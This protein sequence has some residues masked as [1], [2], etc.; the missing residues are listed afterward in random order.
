MT[1]AL[2]VAAFF[3]FIGITSLIFFFL[4]CII[5]LFT[6]PFDRRLRAL[7]LFT[8]FWASLY[9]WVM[10]PW[11]IRIY[12]REKI[13]KNTTYMVVS[14][15]QS[16][17][18]ILVAFRLFFHFKWVSKIE[19]F[20]VPLIGWN[21]LLNRYI[22][23]KRGD[24]ES[25]ARMME[26]SEKRIDEGSSVFFFPEGSRSHDGAVK[27]FKP[28]AFVLAKRKKIP[29]LPI[30]ISGTN[31]A[32]PKYSI[33]YHGVHTILIKVFDEIPYSAFQGL[34][35]EET[36]EMVRDF[37]IQKLDMMKSSNAEGV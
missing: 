27:P 22:K 25:I 34:S 13:K 10:P 33:K 3:S 6:Y 5:R 23:L 37:I 11:K 19:M 17:L 24:K 30:V 31:K 20:R 26:D 18:D 9:T 12:G 15:H 1:N 2:I 32:L 28:G 29:I 36:A 14:N 8:C 4:A 16:Q 35:V 21:M 7:H